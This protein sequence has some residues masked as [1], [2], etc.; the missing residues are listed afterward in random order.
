[1]Y[2]H[3]TTINDDYNYHSLHL[4]FMVKYSTEDWRSW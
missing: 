2:K 1:M 3:Y 4:F